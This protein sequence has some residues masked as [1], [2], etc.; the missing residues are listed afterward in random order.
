MPGGGG[1]HRKKLLHDGRT[2]IRRFCELYCTANPS[3]RRVGPS[4]LVPLP[5][6]W[7]FFCAIS[8]RFRDAT[9]CA[10]TGFDQLD[11]R[12]HSSFCHHSWGHTHTFFSSSFFVFPL[13]LC[14]SPCSRSLFLFRSFCPFVLSFSVCFL[15]RLLRFS[16]CFPAFL[17]GGFCYYSVISARRYTPPALLASLK[18]AYSPCVLSSFLRC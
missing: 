12:T 16:F 9:T 2:F 3:C 13:P 1:V 14:R 18:Y 11:D 7:Q 10:K 15:Y 6:R 17:G 8:C 5:P 4:S